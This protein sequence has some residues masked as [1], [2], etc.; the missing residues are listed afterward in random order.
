MKWH[1]DGMNRYA[2]GRFSLLLG[3]VITDCSL[4]GSGG[5]VVWPGSHQEV[6]TYFRRRCPSSSSS[7]EEEDIQQTF[8]DQ[9]PILQS[10]PV[11]ILA[12]PGDL[13]VCHYSL[14]HSKSLNSNRNAP[15]HRQIIYFRLRHVVNDPHPLSNL[16]NGWNLTVDSS[17]HFSRHSSHSSHSSRPS[18]SHQQTFQN[19]EQSSTASLRMVINRCTRTYTRERAA[20]MTSAIIYNWLEEF[21]SPGNEFQQIFFLKT[22][23]LIIWN[24]GDIMLPSLRV[25]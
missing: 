18:S 8:C 19:D 2:V 6:A 3:I 15:Y 7:E 20:T 21:Y 24:H 13:I 12:S 17:R 14:A 1:V 25:R 4:S 16:Y 22:F 10:T 9:P 11:E 5:L 23:Y